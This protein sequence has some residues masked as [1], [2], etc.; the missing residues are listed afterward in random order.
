MQALQAN[1]S[2]RSQAISLAAPLARL[3]EDG[4]SKLAQ[5]ATGVSALLA[6]CYLA[7]ASHEA[8]E[9]FKQ[10]K[11]TLACTL[12]LVADNFALIRADWQER[13]VAVLIYRPMC[14][15]STQSGYASTCTSC[16]KLSLSH[17]QQPHVVQRQ[18]NCVVR[19]QK[20]LMLPG[21]VKRCVTPAMA[22][23]RVQHTLS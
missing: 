16:N 6:C 21:K 4:A 10:H 22:L 15:A 12:F 19:H 8:D 2:I 1:S 20:T 18:D 7:A 5:R 23:Q 17:H 3:V 9:V 14:F 11:V 13:Q